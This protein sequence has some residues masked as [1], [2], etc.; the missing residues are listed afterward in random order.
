MRRIIQK[1]QHGGHTCDGVLKRM[2]QCHTQPCGKILECQVGE[3]E[4][5]VGCVAD[6]GNQRYR[7]RE[8]VRGNTFTYKSCNLTVRETAGCPRPWEPSKPEC[9]FGP[10]SLWGPC[11]ATCEGQTKRTR[12]IQSELVAQSCVWN[13]PSYELT[14]EETRACG[15][16]ACWGSDEPSLSQ[17]SAWS[18]CSQSCGSGLSGRSR[19]LR[20]TGNMVG[21]GDHGVT[22]SEVR[23]CEESECGEIDCQ[24]GDWDSWSACTC[25]CGGGTKRRSRAIDHPPR[26]GGKLCEPMDKAEVAACATQSCEVCVDGAWGPWGTWSSCSSTCGPSF[27]VRHRDVVQHP[28]SCG[29]AAS[30]LEDEYEVCEKPDC[31]ASSD[32]Q[33]S[34][35]GEWSDCSYECFG[36]KERRRHIV[37]YASGDGKRCDRTSLKEI[38]PCHPG[39]GEP[40]PEACGPAP[41]RPCQTT[42]WA[43]WSTCS[44]TCDGGQQTRSRCILVPNSNGGQPCDAALSQVAPCG[45]QPCKL[46]ICVDCVWSQWSEWGSCSKCGGQ[47]YRHRYIEQMP[48][49]CGEKCDSRPAK[50]AGECSSACTEAAYCVWSDWSDI[51]GCTGTCGSAPRKRQRQLQLVHKEPPAEAEPVG[52]QGQCIDSV[53]HTYEAYGVVANSPEDCRFALISLAGLPGIQ[54]AQFRTPAGPD[55][56]SGECSIR[57]EKNSD[58]RSAAANSDVEFQEGTWQPGEGYGPVRGAD[59]SVGWTCW[60]LQTATFV[61]GDRHIPCYGSQIGLV[62]CAASVP[63]VEGCKP[64]DCQFGSWSD[65]AEPTCTQLC[66]RQRTISIENTCGGKFCTGPLAETKQCPKDCSQPKDC[67]FR[68]WED[69]DQPASCT[70]PKQRFRSRGVL[71]EAAGGGNPCTGPVE[72]TLP[73]SPPG[74]PPENCLIGPWADWFPCTRTCGG[75]IRGRSRNV[76]NSASAG[77]SAC[78]DSLSEMEPCGEQSCDGVDLPCL[79]SDWDDWGSCTD[80]QLTFRERMVRQQPGYLGDSCMGSLKEARICQ[81]VKTDCA[82]GPWSAWDACDQACGGGQQQRHREIQQAASYGGKE[83][84]AGLI[85]SQGCHPQLCEA[86]SCEVSDWSEWDRCSADCGAGQ[87]LRHRYLTQMPSEGSLGCTMDLSQAEPCKGEQ[88]DCLTLTDC[89]WQGWSDWSRCSSSC[90]GGQRA[91]ERHI[92]QM[93][94]IGGK[95]CSSSD[96]EEIEACNT[97]ACHVRVCLDGEW[98]SWT[99]WERCSRTCQG[100]VTWRSRKIK[101][102]AND[103]GTPAEGLSTE[104]RSCN[105]GVACNPLVDCEFG[106]WAE[107]SGCTR[108]CNGVKRR[109][110]TIKVQGQ[111]DGEFCDGALKQT[112]PCNE[113]CGEDGGGPRDCVLGPWEDWGRCSA[114]CGYGQHS[115]ERRVQQSARGLGQGC[116]GALSQIAKCASEPCGACQPVDCQWGEWEVWGYCNKC[117]GE[118]KRYRRIGV[119]PSCGGRNCKPGAAE[120]I[121]NCTRRCYDEAFCSWEDWTSWGECTASCGHGRR[122]RERH[123]VSSDSRPNGK[124]DFSDLQELASDE[125][126]PELEAKLQELQARA[127]ELQ[128]QRLQSLAAAFALGAAAQAARRRSGDA[129]ALERHT[130]MPVATGPEAADTGPLE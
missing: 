17:W 12:T 94:S 33:V 126:V 54:G 73:C 81:R 84:D 113:G 92:S 2:E 45:T 93:P 19:S 85:E 57:V 115:R 112:W 97:Q 91:R 10:W 129:G 117:G 59:G 103:C 28:S 49:S 95:P 62:E 48:N 80:D 116:S 101:R 76:V 40:E 127:A 86:V 108:Q 98:H 65:W 56:H 119:Q 4:D 36:N 99:E 27:R 90:G 123:L 96:K 125:A 66:E 32:C 74:G 8:I 128:A 107:W 89:K 38:S 64:I 60:Q 67:I 63:C 58:P 44:A 51:G 83:C 53:G 79:L 15:Q 23:A 7:S 6:S 118:R 34:D 39:P 20:G 26:S 111:G 16:E 110:R 24:W 105:V 114:S 122:S 102:E 68:E 14:A 47:R 29:K 31:E 18:A 1:A 35:W 30:G 70:L 61:K 55:D 52:D 69:W 22:L 121:S 75:G 88:S 71:R 9:N 25:T 72:E 3:W 5:W 124:A 120:E 109:S 21:G 78:T 11:S 41:A 100:G 13:G 43:E 106:S 104:H 87:R 130:Y 82:V 42:D 37:W 46:R 50:E 77:G